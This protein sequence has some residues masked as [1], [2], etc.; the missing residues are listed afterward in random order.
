MN[1][2]D[3]KMI[4]CVKCQEPMPELRLTKYGYNFCV[5]CSTVEGKVAKT[6]VYGS[7]D[8]TWNDIVI[9]DRSQ[10]RK[11]AEI[12]ATDSPSTPY[13]LYADCNSPGSLQQAIE[14]AKDRGGPATIQL[15]EGTCYLTEPLIIEGGTKNLTIRGAGNGETWISGKKSIAPSSD[16]TYN[17]TQHHN[18]TQVAFPYPSRSGR[19]FLI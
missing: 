11:L 18:N 4:P 17:T 6:M 16:T 5:N 1:I 13:V 12:E 19:P 3:L 7:G 15:P 2:K 14:R 8:H 9:M 10:A